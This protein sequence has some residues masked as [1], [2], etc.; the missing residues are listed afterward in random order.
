MKTVH[1][2]LDSKKIIFIDAG[3][4][5]ISVKDNSVIFNNE[6]CRNVHEDVRIRW[7]LGECVD[8]VNL[9]TFKIGKKT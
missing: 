9:A 5:A 1:V 3:G 8:I 4:G 6:S 7:S 2:F